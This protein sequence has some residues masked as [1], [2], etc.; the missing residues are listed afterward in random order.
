MACMSHALLAAAEPIP[1]D[2][3]VGVLQRRIRELT[4][5]LAHVLVAKYT[6]HKPLARQERIAA[7]A[8]VQ[9]PRQKLVRWVE[10]AALL[11]RSVHERL[12][13]RVLGSGY[14]QVDE[15]PV[16]V[17]DPDRGGH[18]AQAYLWTYLAPR[19]DALV[20]DFD[21]SRSRANPTAFFPLPWSGVLQSDGYEVYR[22]LATERA[23]LVHAGCMAQLRRH[24]FDAFKAGAPEA[25]ELIAGIGA[26]YA[27][28][29]EARELEPEARAARRA[30]ACPPIFG[31]PVRLWARSSQ[32]NL[33][34]WPRPSS[35]T[36][37]LQSTCDIHSGSATASGVAGDSRR[38][39]RTSRTVLREQPRA[40]AISRRLRPS[41]S[42][43][44]IS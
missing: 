25:A 18:A 2:E 20:F 21:L 17:L 15:T 19:A 43:R 32:M 36:T 26:L 11:L 1:N 10:G 41:R 5:L 37:A 33:R 44:S 35:C 39:S 12:V 40:R 23:G 28:E 9:L 30:E 7:R 38:P 24:V 3:D 34:G 14:V 42:R 16:R 29:R 6:D 4:G 31:Y 22:R 13:E 27:I 8:G